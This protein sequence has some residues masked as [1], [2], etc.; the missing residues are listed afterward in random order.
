M[1]FVNPSHTFSGRRLLSCS[2]IIKTDQH[3]TSVTLC[4]LH[5]HPFILT[6]LVTFLMP[7]ML[8]DTLK[9]QLPITIN[10]QFLNM[11]NSPVLH[12]C[13]WHEASCLSQNHKACHIHPCNKPSNKHSA[14]TTIH[15]VSFSLSYN[16]H[17]IT[18]PQLQSIQY[19]SASTTT[20]TVSYYWTRKTVLFG[21]LMCGQERE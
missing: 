10:H 5:V 2:P 13:S 11:C 12:Q 18:Q 9:Y 4:M 6:W 19:H 21:K 16:P 17:S 1:H 7:Q 15:T 14:S 20:H 8:S 3:S